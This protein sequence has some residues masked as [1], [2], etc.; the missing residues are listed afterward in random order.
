MIDKVIDFII[1]KVMK[2]AGKQLAKIKTR[3]K[4][5]ISIKRKQ[6]TVRRILKRTREINDLFS[7]VHFFIAR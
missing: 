3:Q 7:V 5:R 1:N 6:R 2:I 4:I